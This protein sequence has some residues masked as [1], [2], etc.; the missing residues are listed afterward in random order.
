MHSIQTWSQLGSSTGYFGPVSREFFIR[1]WQGTVFKMAIRGLGVQGILMAPFGRS[2]SKP[3][4]VLGHSL[5]G[6][7][8]SLFLMNRLGELAPSAVQLG[9]FN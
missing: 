2:Q 7:A 8:N 6:L 4:A 5:G 3:M 1:Q 9:R